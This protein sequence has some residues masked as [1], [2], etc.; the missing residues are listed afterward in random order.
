MSLAQIALT[1]FVVALLSAGQVLFKLAAID[2]AKLDAVKMTAFLTPKLAI[3]FFAYGCATIMWLFVLR[4]VP[5]R[6]AYPFSALAFIAVP[7]MSFYW[8]G[9]P[10]RINTLIG[11]AV[12]L[13]GVWISVAYD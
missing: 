5:L 4:T 6:L 9:E 7:L 12:I 3:A 8:I 13:A 2:L 10:I 11:A 1:I